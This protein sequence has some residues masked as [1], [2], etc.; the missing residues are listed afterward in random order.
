MDKKMFKKA[1]EETLRTFGIRKYKNIYYKDYGEFYLKF[2]LQSSNFCNGYYL[3]YAIV[4][5]ELHSEEESLQLLT[6]DVGGRVIVK[7]DNK[8]TDLMELE[9]L[10]DEEQF[11]MALNEAVL[12]VTSIFENGGIKKFFETLP[13]KKN[14]IAVEARDYD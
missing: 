7:L 8:P 14:V 9:N 3:N 4:I 2:D 12:D 5:K 10:D 6:S 13:H 1:I 11:M